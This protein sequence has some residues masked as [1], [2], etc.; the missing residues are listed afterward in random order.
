MTPS[1]SER[2]RAL[3]H[4]IKTII[5]AIVSEVELLQEDV[6]ALPDSARRPVE[7]LQRDVTRLTRRLE[8]L[9]ENS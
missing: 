3:R 5:A 4:E 1:D 2:T 6:D 8:N 7:L 9:F